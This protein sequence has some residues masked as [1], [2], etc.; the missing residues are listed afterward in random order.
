MSFVEKDVCLLIK[1]GNR[2]GV[3]KPV[4]FFSRNEVL[5][6]I[7][8]KFC[9]PAVVIFDAVDVLFTRANFYKVC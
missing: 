7:I 2:Y 6:V 3:W 4:M 1:P 9:S 5:F 8:F